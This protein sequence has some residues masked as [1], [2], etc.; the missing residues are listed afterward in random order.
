[1]S[2]ISKTGGDDGGWT[3]PVVSNGGQLYLKGSED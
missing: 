3:K 1:V 2:R